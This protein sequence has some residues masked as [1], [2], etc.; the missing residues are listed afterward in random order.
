MNFFVNPI[1]G[2]GRAPWLRQCPLGPFKSAYG[3]QL[4]VDYYS[5]WALRC[6]VDVECSCIAC[7]FCGFA[8]NVR[9]GLI[10]TRLFPEKNYELMYSIV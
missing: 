5:E 1:S 9:V 3:A 8:G 2:G 6:A 4:L 10:G 7:V